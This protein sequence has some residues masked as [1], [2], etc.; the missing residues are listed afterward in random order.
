MIGNRVLISAS[1]SL[2]TYAFEIFTI[3]DTATTNIGATKDHV[4]QTHRD[5]QNPQLL[6][7]TTFQV[8]RTRCHIWE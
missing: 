1:L 7:R 5:A 3:T 8:T 6:Q 4:Q 2:S